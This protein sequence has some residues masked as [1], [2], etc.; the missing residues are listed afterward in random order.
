MPCVL[1]VL[2][3]KLM[4]VLRAG[5]E[6]R[7]TVRVGFLATAAGVVTSF[8]VLAAGAIAL[9]HA[10]VAIGWGIQFQQPLFLIALSLVL[11][12][13]AGSMI[14]SLE[15][16]L[17][18]VLARMAG[19]DGGGHWGNFLSGAFATLLATP[20]SAPFVG[21]AL[22][23]ALSAGALEVLAIFTA[24][25]IGLAA[26]W[27][28]IAA[29]PAL[30]TLLPRPGR[31]MAVVR[32]VLALAL[33]LTAA[34]LVAI[35]AE[36]VDGTWRN[37][38]VL[39]VAVM[40]A[41]L[42]AR[43]WWWQRGLGVVTAVL[44]CVALLAAGAA[45]PGGRPGPDARAVD[46]SWEEFDPGRITGLVADGR[47]VFV[48]V[49]ADWCLTCK[50]N[51]AVV[52]ATDPVSGQ[53]ATPDVVPMRADWTRPDDA[54]ARYLAGFGRYGIPFNAVYGTG[55]AGRGAPAGTAEPGRGARRACR[56]PR[57][58]MTTPPLGAGFRSR[59]SYCVA[60]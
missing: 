19:V 29:F 51:D 39:A 40:A 3:L 24:M 20:C 58:I 22:G 34:W 28:G 46:G 52:F 12:V 18:G 25:G 59:S 60:T 5:H 6:A 54:I 2:S 11:V 33:A 42:A 8:L 55:C 23:F 57:V 26:P 37:V 14:G 7:S 27:L 43:A 48:D 36:Q 31:W 49:T 56:G 38:T 32:A 10:G 35:A 50:V 17:P 16:R 1:P 47:V 41:A 44:A 30:V 13:F 53:F 4:Q 9:R 21:T 15:I 45:P